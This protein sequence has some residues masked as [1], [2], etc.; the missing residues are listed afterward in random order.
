MNE[1]QNKNTFT[2]LELTELINQFRREEGDRK[3]LQH[4]DLLKVI[5]LEFEEEIADGKISAG[6]YK[7]KQNQERP[8]FILD[9][10]QS[11]QVLVR[12]SKFV[13]K[14]VIKYIDEL[15]N[16]LRGQFQVPTTFA[17]ALR[18]AA[19]QQERIEKLALDNKV[20]DQQILELQPKASY[21]DLILQCKDLLSITVIAKDYGKSAEWMNKKLHE[22]GVQ[23]KQSG[24]WLLYQKYADKGYTQTKTQNYPKTD[25]TQGVKIHMYWSQKGRLFLYNLLKNN[26]IMPVVEMEGTENDR[27]RNG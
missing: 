22:L 12:E 16:K 25:G 19:E 11:R 14:A 6:S 15:E 20:K 3:E 18:L 13:R 5:K 17:D 26:G 8:M 4:Y 10:Q 2:S 9:L 23:F 21:Y 27:K 1:L 24:V 7:D